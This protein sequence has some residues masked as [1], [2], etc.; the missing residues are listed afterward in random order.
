GMRAVVSAARRAAT[1]AAAA[2]TSGGQS[3]VAGKKCAGEST[4]LRQRAKALRH[5]DEFPEIYPDF[6]QSPVWNRRVPLREQL[7]RADMLERRMQLDVPEFYVGSIVAVTTTAQYLGAK[8]HRFV[9]ICIRREKPGLLHQFTL[10]NVIDGQGVEVMYELYNPTIKKIET[11]KLEKRLDSD[12]S[13]LIDAHPEFSTFDPHMEP[14][15]HP[16]G[17]PVPV[18]QLKVKLRPPPWTR[19]WE[20]MGPAG[21]ANAWEDATPWYKRKFHKTKV[22]DYEKYDLIAAYRTGSTLEHELKVEEEMQEF[23]RQRH[24]AGLT[25]RRIFRS[26]AAAK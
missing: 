18:N 10:R 6:V 17:T 13:Y 8:E 19:R 22:N 14:V 2:P 20:V 15:A 7:E 25:R 1:A 21:V 5:I 11:L 16:A 24:A 9:G 26:A 4:A 23:E 12:L 3:A